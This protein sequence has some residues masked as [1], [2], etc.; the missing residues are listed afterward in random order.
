[1]IKDWLYIVIHDSW[2][3]SRQAK[4]KIL[5]VLQQFEPAVWTLIPTSPAVFTEQVLCWQCRIRADRVD[6]EPLL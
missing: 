3:L 1:M 2:L 5:H 4:F 6:K